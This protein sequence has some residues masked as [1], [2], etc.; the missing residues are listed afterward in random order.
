MTSTLTLTPV[1][2]AFIGISH[3]FAARFHE[4]EDAILIEN[5][6][7]IQRHTRVFGPDHSGLEAFVNHVHLEDACAS[8]LLPRSHGRRALMDIGRMLVITWGE[9]MR[10]MLKDRQAIFYLGGEDSVTLRFHVD[11]AD[12]MGWL[13][14]NSNRLVKK[15]RMELYRVDPSQI[16]RLL[17]DGA[18]RRL[19]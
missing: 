8:V 4:Y 14:L 1:A 7:R 5:P 17:P 12:G 13:D 9:R 2:R 11:R 6:I 15:E 16:L 10:P 18:T 3:L 19:Q